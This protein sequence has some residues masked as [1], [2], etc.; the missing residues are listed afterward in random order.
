MRQR[1]INW[2]AARRDMQRYRSPEQMLIREMSEAL[3]KAEALIKAFEC[4]KGPPVE[5]GDHPRNA[6]LRSIRGAL[7]K[8][9]GHTNG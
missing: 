2:N 9:E 6:T 3:K 1:H 4:P 7:R 8:A 5:S